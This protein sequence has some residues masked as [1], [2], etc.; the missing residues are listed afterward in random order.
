MLLPQNSSI[1]AARSIGRTADFLSTMSYSTLD[2]RQVGSTLVV[3]LNRPEKLNALNRAMLDELEQLFSDAVLPVR[4]RAVIITGKGKAFAA[5]ADIAELAACTGETGADFA[6]RGQRVFARIESLPIPVIA[7]VGGY[8]LGGGC[9]LAMA[10]HL[11]FAATTAVFGQPEVKLGIIPGYGGTQRLARLIGVARAVE[12]MLTGEH[13][14]AQRA[15]ELGLVNRVFEPEKLLDETLA[16][17]AT[18]EMLPPRAIEAILRATYGVA[19]ARYDIEAEQFGLL[20]GT[21]DF[22]EGTRAF[23]EKRTPTFTGR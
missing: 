19:S 7:A 21:D 4:Y 5:G 14:S 3:E 22:R 13:I 8:A 9:E 11:R 2:V 6:R 17:C 20:C 10:C 18:L 12:F 16:F 1:F 15:Y 23:L